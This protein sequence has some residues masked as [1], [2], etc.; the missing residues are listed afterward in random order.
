MTQDRDV[1]LRRYFAQIAKRLRENEA[2]IMSELNASQGQSVD[3]GG[4]YHVA[5]KTV[6]DAMRPS[7]TF[8]SIIE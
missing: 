5:N 6:I 1:T 8:N 3:I 7:Q 4:Y 2:K